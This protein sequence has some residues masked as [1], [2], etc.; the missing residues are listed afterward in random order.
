MKGLYRLLTA[1][2]VQD[3]LREAAALL[4]AVRETHAHAAAHGP[5]GA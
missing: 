3:G 4:R 2:C 1:A 5:D